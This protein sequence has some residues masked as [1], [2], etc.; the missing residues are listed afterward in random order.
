LARVAG[1]VRKKINVGL[2]S[3]LTQDIN[4]RTIFDLS[5]YHLPPQL[6]RSEQEES[7]WNW[8]TASK[9]RINI[10]ISTITTMLS[11][12]NLIFFK[13]QL[14]IYSVNKISIKLGVNIV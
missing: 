13:Q 11:Q 3:H 5:S 9:L 8:K 2:F 7:I 14:K 12:G 4:H 1:F 10:T 6:K